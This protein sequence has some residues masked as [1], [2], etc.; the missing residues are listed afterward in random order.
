MPSRKPSQRLRP[1]IVIERHQRV[2]GDHHE[3]GLAE[4]QQAGVAEVHVQA[5]RRQAVDDRRRS[6][7]LREGEAE[8]VAPVHVDS[9]PQPIL[10]G[11]PSRPCG[12]ISSTTM[13]TTS[14]P[15]NL[16]SAGTK[17]VDQLGEQADDEGA[18]DRAPDGAEAAEHDGREDQQQQLE[19]DLVVE[20]LGE[21]E[22]R[23]GQARERG[24]ADPDDV[25]HPLD[26]DA[27]RRRQRRVVGDRAGGLPDPGVLQE[28]RRGEQD[29]RARAA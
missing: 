13:R 27:G 7:R 22:Q 16:N 23:S 26:V 4:V 19:A 3:P 14:A 24:A 9:L 12:L 1:Q 10:C 17:S 5:D 11:L 8:D 21:A 2:A 25:D 29:R 20:A 28:G 6:Q 15:T 18:D